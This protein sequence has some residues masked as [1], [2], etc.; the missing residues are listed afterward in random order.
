M[1]SPSD[2]VAAIGYVVVEFNQ[3]NGRPR[4]L[5]GAE[6]YDERVDA[7]ED[8]RGE[9]RDKRANHRLERYAVASVVI[10]EV[11]DDAV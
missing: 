8:A 4:L 9:L 5:Y 3:A 10:E 7:V 2:P 1:A 6:L 11:Y